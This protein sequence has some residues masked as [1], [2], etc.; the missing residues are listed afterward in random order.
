METPDLAF[1]ESSFSERTPQ[2]RVHRPSRAERGLCRRCGAVPEKGYLTC[3]ACLEKAKTRYSPKEAKANPNPNG[4]LCKCGCGNPL[5]GQATQWFSEK[6][7]NRWVWLN[8][9]KKG[10]PKVCKRPGCQTTFRGG[11]DKLYCSTECRKADW[12][13]CNPERAAEA[14]AK[15]GQKLQTLSCQACGESFE[16]ERVAQTYCDNCRQVDRVARVWH[17]SVNVREVLER[18]G[19]KCQHCGCDTQEARRGTLEDNAPELDHILPLACGGAHSYFNTQCLCRKCNREKREDIAKELR[20]IGV[21]DLEPYQKAKH[22]P[23][24][25]ERKERLCA[26]GCG[27]MFVPSH[28]NTTGCRRGHMTPEMKALCR[29]AGRSGVR[30]GRWSDTAR[31]ARKRAKKRWLEKQRQDDAH[32]WKEDALPPCKAD[33]LA[34]MQAA[35]R[36]RMAG[37]KKATI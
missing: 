7:Q 11:H 18:D 13:R 12:Y 1:G 3:R 20:L 30:G 17:E 21:T 6:C 33:D 37:A 27:Q 25:G 19:W 14:V 22:A 26:C 24:V 5:V 23:I 15:K 28:S 9:T 16:Q 2:V 10:K 4:R 29:Q 35:M 34:A 31:A 8:R 36:M 32:L